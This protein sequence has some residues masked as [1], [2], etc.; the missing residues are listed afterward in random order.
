MNL[1]SGNLHESLCKESHVHNANT[2]A[3]WHKI[4]HA[5]NKEKARICIADSGFLEKALII[6]TIGGGGRANVTEL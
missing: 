2:P 4:L 5:I 1:L 3:H 6:D